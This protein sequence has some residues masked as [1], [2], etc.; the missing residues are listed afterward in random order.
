MISAIISLCLLI[1]MVAFGGNPSTP[2]AVQ[3]F[4]ASQ[5]FSTSMIGQTWVFQNGYGDITTVEVQAAPDDAA[6]THGSH[7]ILHFT[8]NADRAYWGLNIPGAE[9]H[10]LLFQ[11]PD[12]AWRGVADLPIMPQ[13]C[14][15]CNGHTS[16]TLNWHPV[17]GMPIP[18]QIVPASVSSDKVEK[19]PTEYHWWLLN[20]I[21]TTDDITTEQAQDMGLAKWE[22]DFSI[23]SV[24]TPIYKGLAALSH[25][26]EG[27]CGSVACDEEKWYFAPNVGLVE[28]QPVAGPNPAD[29][30]VT[31]KRIK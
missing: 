10:F 13:G 19:I 21:N 7:I 29:P 26:F 12:G 31:I 23:E 14:P 2:V 27:S 22:T 6:G 24:D 18:Y 15:W 16:A 20:D 17:D 1:S 5:L 3:T 11:L 8:K 28:I 4:T 25:Q 9:D 30:N